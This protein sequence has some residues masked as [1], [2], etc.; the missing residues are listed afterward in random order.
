MKRITILALAICVFCGV[1]NLHEPASA[2]TGAHVANIASHVERQLA[3]G[4]TSLPV[5]AQLAY[6]RA[7]A[8]IAD[9]DLEAA[10]RDLEEATKLDPN[11]VD[12]YITLAQ[13]SSRQF[14]FDALFYWIMAC[15]SI[16]RDFHTQSMLALNAVFVA[17]L[18]LF[19]ITLVYTVSVAVRYF[20]FVIHRFSEQLQKRGIAAPRA[21]TR[22]LLL[23]PLF[24]YPSVILAFA[25]V[26]IVTWF[27]MQ[28]REKTLALL[29]ALWFT[30][31]GLFH[32]R[33]GVWDA[34]ADPTS[35]TSL[36]ARSTH[37]PGSA[38]AITAVEKAPAEGLEAEKSLVLG[39][40]HHRAGH[41]DSAIEYFLRAIELK[42]NDPA[43]YIN[44][45][46]VYY[47]RG[48]H[49]KA[50]EGYG[51]AERLDA[52]N[53][54]GQHNLAQAYIKS[55]LM[56]ESSQ[57][58]ERASRAGI[59]RVRLSYAQAAKAHNQVYPSTFTA[60]RLWRIASV[61]GDSR[62]GAYVAGIFRPAN[63]VPIKAAPWILI[64]AF[65]VILMLR[66]ALKQRH[67][68]FQC[69]NCGDI[70]C[71]SCCDDERGSLI[72]SACSEVID[73][74]SSDRVLDALLRQ[75]RQL[76]IV[77]RRKSTRLATS[78]L[79]GV[80][81]FYY[82]RTLRG[83]LLAGLFA[84]SLIQ[85]LTRGY[86]VPD[87]SVLQITTPTWK[88]VL[89][90]AGLLISY[91]MS[92]ASRQSMEVRNYRGSTRPARRSHERGPDEDEFYRTA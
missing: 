67:L 55:L 61:D 92:I 87:W 34:V 66:G 10:T 31:V 29:L 26:T 64:A 86:P 68:A 44:L 11:F 17:L 60:G 84:V 45:G 91:V 47:A 78:W 42:P 23:V 74:V 16:V 54:V 59:D 90:G 32:Q 18:V 15:K 50:L 75:R 14:K 41:Y 49:E 4:A 48:N 71:D 80:R 46:N 43:G 7:L 13:V 6:Q 56:A 20:P 58:L 65:M 82:G 62:Q 2:R 24:I 70:T 81:D 37:A 19:V 73:G 53:P 83:F 22:L 33:L 36:A 63:R 79:P 12:A 69:T 27:F 38:A 77:K 88:W 52:D 3:A 35:F 28:R 5:A 21:T 51:K 25:F 72:C 76:V 30:G 9:G 39:I 85:L 40:Y 89:P 57:A 1:L 8:A